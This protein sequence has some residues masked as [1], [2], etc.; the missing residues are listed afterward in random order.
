MAT[1]V[2]KH[3]KSTV[4]RRADATAVTDA[5]AR[6]LWS[7]T[8]LHAE[9]A[10]RAETMHGLGI[11]SGHVVVLARENGAR[12]LA[13]FLAAQALGAV[14]VPVDPQAGRAAAVAA[15]TSAEA[16]LLIGGDGATTMEGT[17]RH[18]GE[19]CLIKTTSGST[20]VPRLYYFT[21]AQMLADARQIVR[22]MD[23]HPDDVN[24]A[25]IPLG[26]SYGLGNL[27]FPLIAH[28]I[29]LVIGRGFFPADILNDL[30]EHR[31]TV[32]PAVPPLLR[33][34]SETECPGPPA[35]R[36][37]ISAGGKLDSA[38][39]DRFRAKLN[40]PVHN[41][42]GST[43]TGG[44]CYTRRIPQP[45]EPATVGEPLPG[46]RVT[47]N[48][49][50]AVT[51]TGAAVY[52]RGNRRRDGGHGVVTMSDLGS[53]NP[54]GELVLGGR[55]DREVK[56]AGRRLRLA[57]IESAALR[58][59]GVDECFAHALSADGADS[60]IGIVAAGR[61]GPEIL[62]KALAAALPP[63]ARPRR[64]VVVPEMPLTARGKWCRASLLRLLDGE[65][66]GVSKD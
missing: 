8:Q 50:G 22:G 61:T 28:G 64:I 18:R 5:R 47:I 62:R 31:P 9:A 25:V 20:G 48:R 42:Y 6:E 27:V 37:V 49:R 43:E 19:L 45:G 24:Y 30:R 56:V 65:S 59:S 51:V 46:V 41:F 60:R 55:T 38:V 11:R 26:H 13:D 54:R 63:W 33:V 21:D 52:T 16:A 14:A 12:W 44:I 23:L 1:T 40:V 4:A 10:A 53:F 29:S 7:Y 15:G 3:W 39:R 17:R 58:E 2:W 36:K 32:F 34:L 57:E 66:R 35:L